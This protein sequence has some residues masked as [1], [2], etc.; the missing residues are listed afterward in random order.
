[1]I[2][3]TWKTNSIKIDSK[4]RKTC[5][6]CQIH[7]ASFM[8]PIFPSGHGSVATK[9]PAAIKQRVQTLVAWH[10]K[11]MIFSTRPGCV[12]LNEGRRL[13]RKGNAPH[14]PRSHFTWEKVRSSNKTEGWGNAGEKSSGWQTRWNQDET[15]GP[16]CP[17]CVF[18]FFLMEI[19][20]VFS[21]SHTVLSKLGSSSLQRHGGR[22]A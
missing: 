10:R 17:K 7:G 19:I 5:W 14:L 20:G 21:G 16:K 22:V 1:M 4:L 9:C 8:V 6:C 3:K 12:R 13:G 11:P 18:L 15:K 2:G